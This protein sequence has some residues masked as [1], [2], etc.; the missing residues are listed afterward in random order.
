MIAFGRSPHCPRPVTLRRERPQ[1]ASLEGRRPR[2]SRELKYPGRSSTNVGFTRHRIRKCTSRLQPT[3]DGS[4]LSG[5]HLRMTDRGFH[6]WKSRALGVS[7]A[8]VLPWQLVRRD[9]ADA[10][11]AVAGADAI[12]IGPRAVGTG[13]QRR[14]VLL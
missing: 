9:K 12:E 11:V 13:V 2:R 7:S 8:V 14:L 6:D 4:P 1:V 5:S 3:C 10:V